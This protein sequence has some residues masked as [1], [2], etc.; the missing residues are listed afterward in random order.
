MPPEDERV[1]RCVLSVQS[2]FHHAVANPVSKRLVPGFAGDPASVDRL[3]QHIA[4]F[5][6]GGIRS[7]RS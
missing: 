2:Q 5:S 3:A 6:I 4:D 7:L 1:L